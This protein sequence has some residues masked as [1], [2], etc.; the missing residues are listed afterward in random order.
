MG[1]LNNRS[2]PQSQ[3]LSI[4]DKCSPTVTQFGCD[5]KLWQVSSV[6]QTLEIQLKADG[7]H[8]L[9]IAR[10]KDGSMEA[11]RILIPHESPDIPEQFL[12]VQT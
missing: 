3:A 12:D 1:P 5:A 2:L 10:D 7:L 8:C 11:H 6:R 9:G 4:L